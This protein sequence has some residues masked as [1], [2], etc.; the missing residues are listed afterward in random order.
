MESKEIFEDLGDEEKE[1]TANDE[2]SVEYDA[3][4]NTDDV[5]D[6]SDEGKAAV[7]QEFDNT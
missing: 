4:L 7:I 5:S 6:M 1:V 3:I 2:S